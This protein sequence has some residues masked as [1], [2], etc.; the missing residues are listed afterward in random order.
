MFL[1]MWFISFIFHEMAFGLF[2]IFLPLYVTTYLGGG[3][4]DFG[5]MMVLARLMTMPSSF[6]WGYLCD[7]TGKYRAFILLSLSALTLFFFLFTLTKTIAFLTLLYVLIGVFHVAHE[8]PKNVLIAESRPRSEWERGFALY[9][10]LT[11]LGW[12]SGLLLGFTL[13][14]YGFSNTS[15]LLLCSFLHMIGFITSIVFIEDPVLIFERRLARIE[16]TIG[17]IYQG[18]LLASK[19][20]DGIAI[21]GLTKNIS[22]GDN[23]S[24]FCL[25]V[26]LFS[27]ATSS[28]FTPLPIFFSQNLSLP[29]N[30]IFAIFFFN[31]LGGFFGYL[32]AGNLLEHMEDKLFIKGTTLAR[33]F[34]C[35]V[36]SF[37]ILLP[38]TYRL[39]FSPVVLI[40]MGIAYGLFRVST[41]S[42]SMELIPEGRAGIYNTLIDFGAAFGCFIGP[43]LAAH[44]G[45]PYLFITSSLLFILSFAAFK[46]FAI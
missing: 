9:W 25:G 20:L 16:R 40:I 32:I 18:Y 37:M 2:S 1:S 13:S 21:K 27:L 39:L 46:R 12:L 5:V 4:I 22:R 23:L 29:S 41:I 44:F 17:F 34:L 8:P 15:M 11:E 30:I 14:S 43:F 36:F 6:F 45:F 38:L 24:V 26:V 33:G 7:K 28:L 31:S 10:A 35:P 19:V 42:L 3:L